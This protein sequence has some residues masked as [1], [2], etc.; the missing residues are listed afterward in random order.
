M[1]PTSAACGEGCGQCSCWDCNSSNSHFLLKK[2]KEGG[3]EGLS[4]PLAVLL[5]GA[6]GGANVVDDGNV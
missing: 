6:N 5:L 3:S 1:G 2:K 4:L